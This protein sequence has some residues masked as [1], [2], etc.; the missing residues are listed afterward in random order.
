VRAPDGALLGGLAAM[1]GW[2]GMFID[3][4]WV[5][6][7]LRGRGIGRELMRQAEAA[8]RERRGDVVFLNT[9][10]FQAPAFYEKLGY[11]AFGTLE[12]VPP[13]TTRTWYCKRVA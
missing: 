10:S 13:G 12:G 9:W 6:E 7:R 11:T 2:N 8:L 1:Y 3:Y 5:H 4:V